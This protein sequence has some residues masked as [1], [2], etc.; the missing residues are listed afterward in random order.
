MIWTGE[1]KDNKRLIVE[2]LTEMTLLLTTIDTGAN[3]MGDVTS[4]GSA[5]VYPIKTY[6]SPTKKALLQRLRDRLFN[7]R[8]MSE[9]SFKLSSKGQWQEGR[10]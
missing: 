10:R 5:A 7:K 8:S 9:S 1:V 2:K 6:L 4:A 3:M